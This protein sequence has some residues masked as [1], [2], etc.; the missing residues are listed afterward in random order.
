[1]ADKSDPIKD[2]EFQKVIRHFVTTPHKPH[3][4]LR[5]K[6]K[7]GRGLRSDFSAVGPQV[8]ELIHLSAVRGFDLFEGLRLLSEAGLPTLCCKVD[9]GT[10]KATRDGVVHY[11][12]SD[13][14]LELLS[15]LRVGAFH[16]DANKI[17]S[18]P[19]FGGL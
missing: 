2:P 18:A 1:M 11:Q 13:R 7:A 10:A 4:P 5:K 17:E 15:A 9:N 12:L 6:K 16:F 3:E 14:L 19:G 8:N